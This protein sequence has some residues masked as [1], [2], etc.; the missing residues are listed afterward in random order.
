ME[1]AQAS[2]KISFILLDSCSLSRVWRIIF[3]NS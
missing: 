3:R 2:S 1:E